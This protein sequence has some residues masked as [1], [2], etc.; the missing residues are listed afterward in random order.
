MVSGTP[1]R[2]TCDGFASW[3]LRKLR[4]HILPRNSATDLLA[5]LLGPNGTPVPANATRLGY[6][7]PGTNRLTSNGLPPRR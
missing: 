5:S 7:D 1:W 3:Q 6:S 4:S 2:E